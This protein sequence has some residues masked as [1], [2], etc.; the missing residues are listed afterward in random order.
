LQFFY[1]R[2]M[3]G[4]DFSLSACLF[5]THPEGIAKSVSQQLGWGCGLKVFAA[6]SR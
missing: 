3:A 6:G 4:C 2:Q 1:L 5:I